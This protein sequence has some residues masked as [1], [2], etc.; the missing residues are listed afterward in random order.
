MAE[1]NHVGYKRRKGLPDLDQL[2]DLF[3]DAGS[4]SVLSNFRA[5]NKESLRYGFRV[6]L[7]ELAV[8]PSL[9]LDPKYLYLW[10]KRDG[11]VFNNDVK[12]IEL[13]K[14]MVPF[15]P[16]KLPKGSLVSPRN[17]VD[18]ANVE[19]KM[20]IVSGV[21]EVDDLGSDKIEFGDCDMAIS[22]LELYLGKVVMNEPQNEWIGSPEWLT[23]KIS[24]QVYYLDY[25]RFLLLT[26]E[27]LEVYRCLQSGKRHARLSEADLLSL[28]IPSLTKNQQKK[29][30]KECRKKMNDIQKKREEI[31]NLRDD[32]DKIISHTS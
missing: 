22:K 23:Y 14:L 6:K 12:L 4:E 8:R 1:P 7:S 9:R 31:N 3:S 2:N 13:N 15:K 25:L 20:S 5:M 17:L 21:E 24:S 16:N 18:L 26:P 32:I 19:S 29:I 10:V 28:K 11:V 30:A 27:M